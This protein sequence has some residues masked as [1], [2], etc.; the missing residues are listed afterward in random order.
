[1]T[2]LLSVLDN[3]LCQPALP[4]FNLPVSKTRLDTTFS[5]ESSSE[6]TVDVLWLCEGAPNKPKLLSG[7]VCLALSFLW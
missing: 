6:G 5:Q 2:S 4:G 7:L 1:M 3:P